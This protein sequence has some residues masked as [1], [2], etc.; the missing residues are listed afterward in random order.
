MSTE[1]IK[2]IASNLKFSYVKCNIDSFLLEVA[3]EEYTPQQA[4][5]LLLE[6]EYAL[7]KENDITRRLSRARFP[8]QMSFDLFANAHL[9]KEVA[10]EVRV[11]ETLNFIEEGSNVVPIGNPGVGKTALS[12]ALGTKACREGKTVAF[13][14]IPNLVI[15][16]KEAMSLNQP[17]AYKKS[18]EKYDLVILDDL[19]HCSFNKECGRCCLIYSQAVCKRRPSLL[20][21]ILHS[22][23]GMKSLTTQYL[24]AVLLIELLTALML[25]T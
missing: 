21:L 2:E 5:E 6:R 11:L 16:I 9:S 13:I 22:I 14:N 1:R 24:P 20:P 25:W 23:D 8:Y 19:G 18:F 7:R 3:A 4:I 12:I 10:R 15:E 17:T